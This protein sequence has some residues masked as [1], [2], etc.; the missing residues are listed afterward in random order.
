MRKI[1]TF[2]VS[3]L[4]GC[5]DNPHLW[6][7]HGPDDRLQDHLM[8]SALATD[9]LRAARSLARAPLS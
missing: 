6:P 9:A 8:T 5:I 2:T 7:H 3:T 1:A 4:D